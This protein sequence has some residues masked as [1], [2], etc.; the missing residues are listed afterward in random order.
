MMSPASRVLKSSS[1]MPHS[2]PVATSRTSSLPRRSDW[3]RPVKIDLTLTLHARLGRAGDLAVGH[4][5]AGDDQL[6]TRLEDLHDL[7]VAVHLLLVD[8]LQQT[9][10][11][12]L[13]VLD[14]LVDDIVGADVH[15]FDLRHPLGGAV[16]L[17]VEGD[18]DRLRRRRQVD[19]GLADVA[20]RVVNQAHL[21]V[22]VAD[23]RE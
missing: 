7:G 11:G 15:A 20:D 6:A 13:D 14:E 10:E 22:L 2:K 12:G 5:T 23:A 9:L 3:T 16:H 4:A 21:Q 17:D 18:D 19:V 8:R 1:V